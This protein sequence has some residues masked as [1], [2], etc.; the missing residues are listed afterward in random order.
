VSA[1]PPAAPALSGWPRRIVCAL[2][3]LLVGVT[4]GL[5]FNLVTA[6]LTAAQGALSAT[7]LEVAWLPTVYT[8]VNASS[9]L[10]LVKFRQQYGFRLFADLGIG[11]FVLVTGAHLLIHGLGSAIAVRAVSGFAAAPLTTLALFYMM[12]AFPPSL[13]TSAM[14]LGIGCSQLAG[15]L[16][17]I[18]TQDLLETG[19]WRGLYLPEAGLAL[20]SLVA[21]NVV[22]LTPQ[23]R[24]K[25]FDRL[26]LPSFTLFAL[27]L[28]L[29]CVVL[30]LGR[31]VW[32]TDAPWLGVTLAVGVACLTAALLIELNRAHP[33]IDVRWLGAEM[34][35]LC[36][37]LVVFR[38]VL[39]EQTVGAVGL[40]QALG[41]N[42]DQM[43]GLF[44]IVLAATVAGF[45]TAA[46]LMNPKRV[47]LPGLAALLLI[48]FGAWLDSHATSQT[49][50][51]Q[52]Y[53]SQALLAFAG[54]LFLP[55]AMLAG[56]SRAVPRGPASIVSF[57]AVF[58][59]GQALGGLFGT[60]LLATFVTVRQ[61]AH[62]DALAERMSLADPEVSLR[63]RQLAGPFGHVIVDRARAGGQGA[64]LLAQQAAREATVRAYDDLFVLIMLIALASFAFFAALEVRDRLRAARPAAAGAAA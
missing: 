33:M 29:T 41:L 46:F 27:G 39:S 32:W 12:E 36:V 22:R 42:N 3:S 25:A 40:L 23:P 21:V 50:P 18:V 64:A 6:N 26:D 8:A 37:A 44:W 63:L 52:M 17:R 7:P 59:G 28:G 20:M 14:A 57:I 61:R 11:L 48:A 10:L 2:I 35:T 38:I 34:G 54:A 62:L 5:G 43:T 1:T 31:Y 4:Q 24:V 49:R 47:R 19:E 56:I 30:G 60:S 13:R 55:S 16:S 9:A 45:V 15:P 53:V 58:A 51:A